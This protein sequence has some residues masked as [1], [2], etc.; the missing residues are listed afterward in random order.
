MLRDDIASG[1][2]GTPG[3]SIECLVLGI[4][5][6]DE[7]TGETSMGVEDTTSDV[8]MSFDADSAKSS[9]SLGGTGTGI[10]IGSDFDEAVGG[11]TLSTESS[12]EGA[13]I[14]IKPVQDAIMLG[15]Q[16]LIEIVNNKQLVGNEEVTQGQLSKVTPTAFEIVNG[17]TCL[18]KVVY[19]PKQKC[20]F[21]LK[22]LATATDGEKEILEVATK[23]EG[24]KMAEF[25]VAR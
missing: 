4:T 20:F 10:A 9:C 15:N 25:T 14:L 19:K 12:A 13:G 24:V 7:C 11:G 5:V 1:G 18:N 6:K 22:T 2:S 17:A 16:K 21:T 23:S 3:W 8:E